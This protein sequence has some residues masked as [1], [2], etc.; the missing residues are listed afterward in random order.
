MS[1]SISQ[2]YMYLPT[3][4][5][6]QIVYFVATSIP[7]PQRQWTLHA[8]CL[9]SRQWYS[10]A[11]PFLYENPQLSAETAFSGFEDTV[12]PPIH[13]RKNKLNP[14]RFVRRLDLCHRRTIGLTTTLLDRVKE[15]L[16]V[17]VA[18]RLSFP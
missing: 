14:G 15:S 11:I 6:L 8:C 18:P 17:F 1:S 3:E 5:I 9:T 4:I 12:C 16:E 2:I 7:E 13:T 10:V